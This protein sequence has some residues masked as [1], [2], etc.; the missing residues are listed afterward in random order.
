MTSAKPGARLDPYAILRELQAA[1]VD[2][3]LIGGLARVV[4]GADET[5]T[6]LDLAPSRR[7]ANLQRL[8]RALEHLSALEVG[9]TIAAALTDEPSV[10]VSLP[11][12]AGDLK[13]IL[14]PAGTRGYPDLRRKAVRAALGEGLRP[15][16]AAPGDLVRMLEA[17]HRPADNHRIEMLRRVVE[18]DRGLVIDF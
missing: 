18:L 8:D 6:G 10:P 4:Q 7:D 1:R 11:T 9:G 15:Q 17:L 16:I 5:A 14:E 2:Y 3:V 13:I 12:R